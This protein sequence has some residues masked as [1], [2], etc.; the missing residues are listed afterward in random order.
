VRI[1]PGM[2]AA[3]ASLARTGVYRKHLAPG[4]YADLLL[5]NFSSRDQIGLRSAHLRQRAGNWLQAPRI[6]AA[7]SGFFRGVASRATASAPDSQ[8]SGMAKCLR[9]FRAL[10]SRR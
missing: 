3:L 9:F 4:Q 2:R 7:I 8:A 10:G 1:Q 5:A 6:R